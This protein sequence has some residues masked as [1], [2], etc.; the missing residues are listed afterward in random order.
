MMKGILQGIRPAPPLF[1]PILFS[2]G[3]RIE[4]VPLHSFLSNPTKISNSLRRIRTHV[5]SDGVSCYFDPFLE[6]EALGAKL[7]WRAEGQPPLVHW[8]GQSEK[9]ELPEGIRPAN[10][11]AT[12]GRIPVAVE[13]IRR[14][15]SL[16]RDDSLLMAGVTGPFTLAARITQLKQEE[17]LHSENYS[18]AALELSATLIT[19]ISSTYV[20][21]GANLIFIR[22]EI[23]PEL[24]EENCESLAG[25]LAPAINVIRFHEALPVLR[26]PEGGSSYARQ[27]VIFKR[28]WDCVICAGVD[29]FKSS[30]SRGIIESGKTPWG[31]ALPLELFEGEEG[32]SQ[33]RQSAIR[34]LISETRPSIVTTTGDVPAGTDLKRVLKVLDTVPRG[35]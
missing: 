11:A 25:L 18:P 21:A 7:E 9:D 6:T 8:L 2:I 15:N 26:M 30:S 29:V 12:S 35:K 16:L 24:M 33:Q 14:M 28:E 34:E 27:D 5:Q 22:E 20:A 1:L 13:V 3:A 23:L 4:N 19:Q 32:E 10:Q 31:I 17:A